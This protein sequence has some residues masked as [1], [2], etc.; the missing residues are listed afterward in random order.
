M[1]PLT[2]TN[3]NFTLTATASGAAVPGVVSYTG[4]SAVFT[5][6]SNLAPS[7]NYTVTVKGGA[8]G[9]A[10]LA[11]NVMLSNFTISWTTAAAADTTP[12][13]VTGTIPVNGQTNVPINRQSVQPS[14]KE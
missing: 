4:V 1:N 13:T 11:G 3:A 8:G 2:I 9:V 12:P 14:A 7:T 6:S 5:P 10:D